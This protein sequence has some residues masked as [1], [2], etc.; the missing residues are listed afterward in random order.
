MATLKKTHK[1]RKLFAA[2][3]YPVLDAPDN[4]TNV[5]PPP[6]DREDLNKVPHASRS[7]TR[8]KRPSSVPSRSTRDRSRTFRRSSGCA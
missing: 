7:P 4:D 2:S 5:E 3:D 6:D 8:T 1:I